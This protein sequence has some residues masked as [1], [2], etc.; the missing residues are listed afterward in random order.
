MAD[1]DSPWKEALELYFEAFVAFFRPAI[2]KDV[3]WSRGWESLDKELQQLA[4]ASEQG[5]RY[6]DKLM[7]VWRQDGSEAWVL[8]HVEVQT[9]P[10]TDFPRRM[11]VYSYRIRDRYNRPLASLAV[12][13][14]DDPDWRPD[15]YEE[16]LWGCTSSFTF[17]PSKLLDWA[18]K[19]AALEANG[20]PFAKVVLAHLAALRTRRDAPERQT[21]KLRLV[22]GLYEGGFSADDV[23][24]LFRLIDWLMELPPALD[25]QFWKDFDDFQ[26]ERAMPFMTTPERIAR[27]DVMWIAIEDALRSKFGDAGVALMP[28]VKN[29]YDFQQ[30]R[31]L[32]VAIWTASSLDDV[33]RAFPAPA[34]TDL[35]ES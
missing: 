8:I 7:K 17:L 33:R 18:G 28:E 5:R 19:E 15:H 13:A 32:N 24:K 14:D 26:K 31:D 21:W 22:R 29:V 35:T 23:R 11:Y 10:E 30:L 1:Y 20:N 9:T 12:L 2:H 4:V 16:E 34:P 25:R 6:V 27:Q 3:D